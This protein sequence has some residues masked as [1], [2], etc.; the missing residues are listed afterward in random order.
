MPIIKFECE[1]CCPGK[2]AHETSLDTIINHYIDGI[3]CPRGWECDFRKEEQPPKEELISLIDQYVKE[4]KGD[5]QEP[6]TAVVCNS[7]KKW[8]EKD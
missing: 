6:L 4:N 2:C 8:L 7:I 5:W 1:G 3:G